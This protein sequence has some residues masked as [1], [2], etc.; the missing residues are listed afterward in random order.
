M[1]TAFE[2]LSEILTRDYKV[3]PESLAL[4]APLEG[5]GIDSLATVEL[6]WSVEDEF[7]IKFTQEPTSVICVG[8]VV[9]HIAALLGSRTD[10]WA[11]QATP[12]PVGAVGP[13]IVQRPEGAS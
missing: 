6:M 11:A 12:G 3:P 7:G 4:S 1:S 13:V 10:A 8:D 2:R 5:L 9:D